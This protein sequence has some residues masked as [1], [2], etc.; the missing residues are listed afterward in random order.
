MSLAGHHQRLLA[1]GRLL[2]GAGGNRERRLHQRVHAVLVGLHV[3]EQRLSNLGQRHAA[4]LAIQIVRRLRQFGRAVL[5]IGANHPV[6]HLTVV[7]DQNDQH[8]LTG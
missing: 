7:Q 8:P 2:K 1:L 4:E 5:A 3:R 6:L